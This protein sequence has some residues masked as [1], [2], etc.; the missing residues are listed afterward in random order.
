MTAASP[1]IRAIKDW[2]TGLD[3]ET[4]ALGRALGV[5][6]ILVGLITGCGVTVRIGFTHPPATAG[7]W[8]AFLA[9]LGTY[10]VTVAGAAWAMIRGTHATE[11][12]GM[13]ET[14]VTTTPTSATVTTGGPTT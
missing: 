9:G 11:P 7:E 10:T 2:L 4:Y 3:G 12:P 5:L 8:G 14:T 13:T 1:I 6:I